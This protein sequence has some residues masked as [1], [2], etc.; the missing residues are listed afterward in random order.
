MNLKAS[1]GQGSCRRCFFFGPKHD[2][3]IY[4]LLRP[5]VPPQAPFSFGPKRV[6]ENYMCCQGLPQSSPRASQSLLCL[7]SA[8]EALLHSTLLYSTLLY[9][10]LHYSTLLYSTLLS[11]CGAAPA[12]LYD[13]SRDEFACV[14]STLVSKCGAIQGTSLLVCTL[15]WC[16]SAALFKCLSDRHSSLKHIPR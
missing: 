7:Q 3:G 10:T 13:R 11:K 15:L 1:S 9:S 6:F 2:L 16:L 5:R 12:C 14:Y 8:P 4:E